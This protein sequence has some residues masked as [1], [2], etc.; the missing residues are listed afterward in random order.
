V[1][2]VIKLGVIERIEKDKNSTL[3]LAPNE[4][5]ELLEIMREIRKGEKRETIRRLRKRQKTP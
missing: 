2:E 5:S 4:T 3:M 1:L